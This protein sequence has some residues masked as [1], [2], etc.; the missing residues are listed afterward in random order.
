MAPSPLWQEGNRAKCI[1]TVRLYI[2]MAQKSS[3]KNQKKRNW[4]FIAYPE[5]LPAGWKEQL[6]QTGVK[7]AIS[8]LHDRD[9]NPTG[10]RKKPHYHVI[11]CYEGPTTYNTVL[12]LTNVKLGQSIPQAVESV[13]GCYRYL[14]H[15][16]NPEKAQYSKADIQTLNGFDIRDWAELKRS[17]VMKIIRDI[18]DF[19]RVNNIVEYS[20]LLDILQSG[21]GLEDWFEVAATHTLLFTADLKSRRHKQQGGGMQRGTA[22]RDNGSAQED[23]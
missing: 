4:T 1:T 19:A 15:Q 11:L 6:E 13:E 18:R 10:E 14:T 3:T 17:E 20:D 5:S 12:A 9:L 22:H 23:A 8:P 7:C 16:D 21:I 2:R